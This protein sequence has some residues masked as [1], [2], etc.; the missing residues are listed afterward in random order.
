[1]DYLPNV[2][3]ISCNGVGYDGIDVSRAIQRQVLITHTP[4]VLNAETSTT[5]I[6]LMLACY[7]NFRSCE[8]HARSGLWETQGPHPLTQTA[9]NRNVGILGMGRIG[10]AIAMK[11]QAFGAT[12]QYHSRRKIPELPYRYYENLVDMAR[13]VD[14]LICIVPG[15]PDTKHIVNQDVINALG[16]EGV[17]INVARGCVV[18]EKELI[19]ALKERRLGWAGLDVFENEP[20]IPMELRSLEN[21][22]LLPHI[23]SA[24]R[25]TRQAMEDLTIENILSHFR[26]Q[27]V[28]T[29][30]PECKS[31]AV[32]PKNV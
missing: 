7:R 4:N 27:S 13:D 18:D 6:M 17:L 19:K 11:A 29:P 20:Y 14:C 28:L 12:I 8:F 25:E 15:G 9:D 1:M 2:S 23:G 31:F 22:V 32:D 16:P 10:Q 3:L 30:I 5:A 24:T 21:V 26:D